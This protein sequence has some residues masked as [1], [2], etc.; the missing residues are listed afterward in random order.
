[1]KLLRRL[2]VAVLLIAGSSLS[3][4]QVLAQEKT[5]LPPALNQSSSLA[6]IL[7]WLDKNAFPKARV[8]VRVAGATGPRRS[9]GLPRQSVAGGERIFS[10]G[11]HIKETN[12]CHVTLSNELVRI[13]DWR[14]PSSGTFHRFIPQ[15][16]GVRELTPQ[17]ALVFLPLSKMS[18][19]RGKAPF[20]HAEDP[21]KAKLL[22]S[23]RT[24]FEQ[25]GFFSKVIFDVKLIA[26]EEPHPQ[27][28]GSFDH[29]TFT[30]DSK[31]LAEQ[32]N[33]A[34]R[35]AIKICTSK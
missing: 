25:R 33:A 31:E 9:F 18:D 15:K 17:L 14:N 2:L 27:E 20:L 5:L 4:Y 12:D 26:A 28:L 29:V 24:S 13:I 22:G 30:F 8:G 11:F 7:S 23:W 19:K 32:F 1:M 6:E 35:Q 21:E 3:G 34:F 16:N 10:E